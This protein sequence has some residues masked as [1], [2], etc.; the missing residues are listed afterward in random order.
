MIYFDN[1]EKNN[2]NDFNDLNDLNETNEVKDLE[3]MRVEEIIRKYKHLKKMLKLRFL[4]IN[5]TKFVNSYNTRI[6][7]KTG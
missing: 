6:K 3:K 4:S 1:D 7:P 5:Y 2:L